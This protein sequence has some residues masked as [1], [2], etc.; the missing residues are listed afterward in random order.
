MFTV[1][2][3]GLKCLCNV[4]Y[5]C[6]TAQELCCSNKTVDCIILRLRT[7]FEQNIEYLIKYFDIKLLFILTALNKEIRYPM[8]YL[9]FVFCFKY[10]FVFKTKDHQ[11]V[12]RSYISYGTFR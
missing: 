8:I 7:Y 12:T 11:R 6:Q 2:V 1:I 4:V 3:E 9:L 10:I 5:N